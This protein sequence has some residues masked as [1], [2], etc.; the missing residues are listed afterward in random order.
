MTST[1]AAPLTARAQNGDVSDDIDPAAPPTRRTFT[2]EQK[3]AILAAYDEAT[4]LGAKGA[5]LRSEG[6]YSS[7]I[8][9]WKKAREAGSLAALGTKSRGVRSA[10]AKEADRLRKKN[11]RLEAELKKTRTALDIVGKAHALLEMLSESADTEEK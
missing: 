2:P 8:T 11:E 6:I 5:L 3:L 1:N 9:E 4:E 10:D 7:Q